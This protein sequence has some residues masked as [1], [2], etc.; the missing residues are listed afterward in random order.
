MVQLRLGKPAPSV[1]GQTCRIPRP[2]RCTPGGHSKWCSC[3]SGSGSR[4]W[5]HRAR[6]RFCTRF[7]PFR[8]LV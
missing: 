2:T 8:C 4:A 6:N 1:S 5:G 3:L 7:T